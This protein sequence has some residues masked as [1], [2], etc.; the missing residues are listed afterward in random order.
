MRREVVQLP[1]PRS[2]REARLKLFF[3]ASL[4]GGCAEAPKVVVHN[5]REAPRSWLEIVAPESPPAPLAAPLVVRDQH[6]DLA[7]S[8]VLL[9]PSSWDEF[10]FSVD[11]AVLDGSERGFAGVFARPR[12]GG[13]AHVLAIRPQGE[14]RYYRSRDPRQ[15]A[16]GSGWQSA[17]GQD[18]TGFWRLGVE[19]ARGGLSLSVNGAVVVETEGT[20]SW[21]LGVFASDLATRWNNWIALAPQD[22][23]L[24]E[25]ASYVDWGGATTQA[26]LEDE[27][28]QHA[29]EFAERPSRAGVFAMAAALD[30]A[31]AAARSEGATSEVTR[32]LDNAVLTATRLRDAARRSGDEALLVRA[33]GSV[34]QDPE[35]RRRVFGIAGLDLDAKARASEA[36][37][38]AAEALVFSAA[39]LEVDPSPEL[40]ARVRKL[41]A[42]LLPLT[43]RFD[44][45][46][47]AESPHEHASVV[48]SADLSQAVRAAF[49]GLPRADRARL[50]VRIEIQRERFAVSKEPAERSVGVV[51]G[52]RALPAE[53]RDELEGLEQRLPEEITAARARADLLKE[54]SRVL[55]PQ[56]MAGALREFALGDKSYELAVEDGR[57]L[58]ASC[59]RLGQLK[60]LR[61]KLD[62]SVRFERVEA[63]RHTVQILLDATVD[64]RYAGGDLVRGERLREYRGVEQWEHR[65][66]PDLA[67]AASAPRAEDVQSALR[68]VQ[69][70]LVRRFASLIS[71]ESVVARLPAREKLPF[72]I[73]LA[74]GTR[75]AAD[76][77]SLR[78]F[79]E[80]EYGGDGIR[81]VLRDAAAAHI[82]AP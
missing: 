27:F 64:V 69:Q 81:G 44:L 5:F 55:G 22:G 25:I 3:C 13:E 1:G 38:N 54:G 18:P 28:R 41:K 9:D 30:A 11:L 4:L 34:S 67:V 77:V 82:L 31:V 68:T 47:T 8:R 33:F 48:P 17:G 62:R 59:R 16:G 66:F 51:L 63:V 74:R 23:A 60:S 14:W 7:G 10:R 24:P 2:R 71:A 78:W 57:E 29:E 50:Q 65:A 40:E 79:L 26:R 36:A 49:G 45:V 75:Q 73:G 58:E 42:E 12:D 80:Q 61:D 21:Q 53:L 6:L 19:V 15:P 72:L 52:D 32:L 43:F 35:A 37:G 70:R 46:Q 76:D 20:S 56:R 39:L